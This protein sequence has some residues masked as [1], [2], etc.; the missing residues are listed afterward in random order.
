MAKEPARRYATARD[1]ADDLR[2]FLKGEAIAARPAGPLEKVARWARRNPA[3]AGSLAGVVLVLAAGTV[4]S[5][6]FGIDAAQQAEKARGKE[7]A[8]VTANTHLGEANAALQQKSDDLEKA[9]AAL[10]MRGTELD[11][12]NDQLETTLARSLLRPLGL[13]SLRLGAPSQPLNDPE[14]EALRELAENRG[15]RLG[16]RFME[17]ALR[18]PTTTQQLR[19]RAEWAM[20][21]AV[22]LAP[23]KRADPYPGP[24]YGTTRAGARPVRPPWW[25]P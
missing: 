15:E 20:H 16:R 5:T 25:P 24:F 22:G 9:N 18:S 13:Q 7:A 17:E 1:L 19:A 10:R 14:I 8:A 3:L 21:A 2:R 6:Y 12:A 4:V 11:K 23:D